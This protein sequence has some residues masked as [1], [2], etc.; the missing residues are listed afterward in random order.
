M[1]DRVARVARRLFVENRD[2][3]PFQWLSGEDMPA[4]LDEAYAIQSALHG[5]WS[6]EGVGALGGWKI[7]ITSK[8]MQELCGID[9]PCVGGILND[10]I[11]LG[12]AKVSLSDYVRL[13]LEFELALTMGADA[14]GGPYDAATIRPL[15]AE[16]RPAF[17]LIE[18]RGA[19]YADFDAFS[20]VA[21]NTWNGG[22]VAGPAIPNWK[23]V[24]WTSAPVTLRY[25][26]EV[27]T[28]TTGEAL[29]DPFAAIA[30]VAN[31]LLERGTRLKAGDVVMTGSTL[32]TRFA[33]SGD[34]AR[35]EID[36]LGAVEIQ[37]V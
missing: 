19:D 17:E 12:P 23:D 10:R 5:L 8:A 36:G 7:A 6:K 9:Q 11:F 25:N 15:V 34:R 2:R 4:D 20:L 27:E 21:D 33:A 37:V 22:V 28:A 3:K 13:G 31:N 35:Y 14:G 18:D 1:T 16:A 24:D 26:D 32:K 30:V 29:G